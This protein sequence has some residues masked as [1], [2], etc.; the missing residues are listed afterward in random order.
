MHR[1]P[2]DR[3]LITVVVAVVLGACSVSIAPS[4]TPVATPRP[5]ERGVT[6]PTPTNGIR[7]GELVGAV[8]AAGVSYAAFAFFDRSTRWGQSTAIAISTDG[9]Q[10]A[11]A[12]T[13]DALHE[14][15]PVALV[16]VGDRLVLV[17][18]RNHAEGNILT[19]GSVVFF[20]DDGRHWQPGMADPLLET[21]DL[22]LAAGTHNGAVAVGH[23]PDGSPAIW[24]TGDGADWGPAD[25]GDA[26]GGVG[27]QAQFADLASVAGRFVLAGR[28]GPAGSP[29][30]TQ[31]RPALWTS[32]DG[33][34]WERASIGLDA[35]VTG[36][37]NLLLPVPAGLA[38]R[39]FT[40][41]DAPHLL[42]VT[43]DGV[44]WSPS[45]SPLGGVPAP[46]SRMACMPTLCVMLGPA[47]AQPGASPGRGA[48]PSGLADPQV[49]TA[50]SSSDGVT[51][52]QVPIHGTPPAI[53]MSAPVPGSV[54]RGYTLLRMVALDDEILAV[55]T[56]GQTA[57]FWPLTIIP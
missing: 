2:F 24:W 30:A 12:D 6:F 18:N 26:F 10:W 19:A 39:V 33:R 32:A 44:S 54:I 23:H 22:A 34:T 47:D 11:E 27:E 38:V 51:W 37:V 45:S 21:D 15:N 36:D 55:G 50:V 4:P 46:D 31:A 56:N 41:S 16:T 52:Q 43:T 29:D 9:I 25:I 20:S 5:A 17:A 53:Q 13:G 7:G 35:G 8:R 14:T 42:F 40:A 1:R 57:V 3:G 28:I 48:T 49:I